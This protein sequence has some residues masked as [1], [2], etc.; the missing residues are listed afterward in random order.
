MKKI[1]FAFLTIINVSFADQNL[2]RYMWANYRQF[3]GN[4]QQAAKWYDE[5]LSSEKPSIYSNKGYIN[6]LAQNNNFQR[7]VELIPKLDHAFEKDPEVQLLF[8]TALKK[9]KNIAQADERLMKLHNDFK[10]NPE[11]VFQAAESLIRRKELKNAL[12]TIDEYLNSAPRRPNNFIFYFLKSQIYAQLSNYKE[13]HENIKLC[14]EAH[15]KFPQGWLLL[16]LIEEQ[17]GKLDKAIEGYTSYLEVSGNNK[18]VEQHLLGLVMKQ[19]AM[20]Q[21]KQ[22]ITINRS[23]FEKA[24]ILF[25]RQEYRAALEQ[26]NRCL[27]QN[28]RTPQLRL[29]KLEILSAIKQ[30]DSILDL[31]V[32]WSCEADQSQIWLKVLH[33]LSRSHRVPHNSVITSLEKIHSKKPDMVVPMLYL[34]DLY[35]K[36]KN[37]DKALTYHEK[38]IPHIG[39]KELKTRILYQIGIIQYEKQQY[40]K[41]AQTIEQ[42]IDLGTEYP[43]ALNLLAYHYATEEKQLNKAET[44]ITKA[45]KKDK[46][47]PHFLD[48]KAL[49]LYKQHKYKEAL[50]ILKPVI[51]KIPNDS[52]A[53]IH[54][55]KI[56]H[57]LGDYNNACL[58]LGDAKKCAIS[59]YEK[60]TSTVLLDQ[61]KK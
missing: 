25:E 21:K 5:I 9:T 23:C 38:A 8:I 40:G 32:T 27:A 61:W 55:S 52:T 16:A 28:V 3:G 13:A 14:L 57:K 47:N 2:H 60:Q 17:N 24:M 12:S 53:L 43:P 33:L 36:V 29:L 49:L 41:M 26:I 46:H 54:L 45:L 42:A 18:Q 58:T 50:A 19:K 4:H 15:P 51:K 30:Y 44:L 6:L 59:P 34:A 22:V 31:L 37:S 35:S 20:S 7:I 48:T 10:T 1:I 11:I 39:N 56:Y